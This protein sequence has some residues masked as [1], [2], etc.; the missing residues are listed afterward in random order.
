MAS[1]HAAQSTLVTASQSV[2]D[3]C[4]LYSVDVIP[5]NTTAT[6]HTIAAALLSAVSGSSIR[7]TI[8][9]RVVDPAKLAAAREQ[10]LAQKAL[11]LQFQQQQLALAAAKKEGGGGV[12]DGEEDASLSSTTRSAR[13]GAAAGGRRNQ[14]PTAASAV[15]ASSNVF[16]TIDDNGNDK[17][18]AA[19]LN[20]SPSQGTPRGDVH[21]VATNNNGESP[22]PAVPPHVGGSF[23]DGS[24]TCAASSTTCGDES[25]K[26]QS[27]TVVK[28][29]DFFDQDEVS[30]VQSS[31]TTYSV[32]RSLE[33]F[34]WF[35][36]QLSEKE[37]FLL[38]GE[39][40]TSLAAAYA[41][42]LKTANQITA[43]LMFFVRSKATASDPFLWSLL[44]SPDDDF[45]L[46]Y[47]SLVGSSEEGDGEGGGGGGNGVGGG[48]S[49]DLIAPTDFIASTQENISGMTAGTS[50]IAPMRWT[51]AI[52]NS[53]SVGSPFEGRAVGG[54]EE[55]DDGGCGS[56]SDSD[57]GADGEA[58]R[59]VRYIRRLEGLLHIVDQD[60]YSPD[61]IKRTRERVA[62]AGLMPQK[63]PLQRRYERERRRAARRAKKT[64]NLIKHINE[65]LTLPDE[66]IK[67]ERISKGMVESGMIDRAFFSCD[68]LNVTAASSLHFQTE[69]QRHDTV[70]YAWGDALD[71]AYRLKVAMEDLAEA[72]EALVPALRDLCDANYWPWTR[73]KVFEDEAKPKL[74]PRVHTSHR[75]THYGQRVANIHT[76]VSGIEKNF[77]SDGLISAITLGAMLYSG[78][79]WSCAVAHQRL[80]RGNKIDAALRSAVRGLDLHRSTARVAAPGIV[81]H[82][83]Y[84]MSEMRKALLGVPPIFVQAVRTSLTPTAPATGRSLLGLQQDLKTIFE[85]GRGVSEAAMLDMLDDD[86]SE[87]QDT[88]DDVIGTFEAHFREVRHDALYANVAQYLRELAVFLKFSWMSAE[89]AIRDTYKS[90][91]EDLFTDLGREDLTFVWQRRTDPNAKYMVPPNFKVNEYESAGTMIQQFRIAFEKKKAALA[92]ATDNA[93]VDTASASSAFMI[94]DHVAKQQG[95]S[96]A[97]ALSKHHNKQQQ[98]SGGGGG[99]LF[100]AK[101]F[102][103]PTLSNPFDMEAPPLPPATAASHVTIAAHSGGDSMG[104]EMVE[105]SEA[106]MKQR[107]F[108]HQM[109]ELQIRQR[110]QQLQIEANRVAGVAGPSSP[111]ST[112]TAQRLPSSAAADVTNGGGSSKPIPIGNSAG[113]QQQQPKGSIFASIDD[114][115]N[116]NS[117]SSAMGSVGSAGTK[118]RRF[119]RTAIDRDD[120]FA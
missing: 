80:H 25:A 21:T 105:T 8:H 68:K 57:G 91:D 7:F 15:I 102:M 35:Q 65:K 33:H 5:M 14:M 86:T 106:E 49:S 89:L 3:Q 39:L 104:E 82:N 43:L 34:V 74:S 51:F 60:E 50:S 42:P 88:L 84:T 107:A 45:Q 71:A 103:A 56:G 24:L 83:R 69:L 44:T 119:G 4:G 26:Q 87:I 37:P 16:D 90:I 38:F 118:K 1:S 79:R 100:G 101:P 67:P 13:G 36:R 70:F 75:L 32:T 85:L 110:Q 96:S 29:H 59:E 99:G 18:V 64:A 54:R 73:E 22:C 31:L 98:Q 115:M 114:N 47:N 61:V 28:D 111:I 53:W 117:T 11:T 30:V 55:D 78:H 48:V 62:K 58:S 92:L 27:V 52:G 20:K 19:G 77:V 41:D 2:V 94:R 93:L 108:L 112:L 6:S 63:T 17:D 40:P 81:V 66:E 113:S 76:V 72:Q 116:L 109:Q 9:T 46:Q 120:P 95:H 23:A 97:V 10:Q 12:G